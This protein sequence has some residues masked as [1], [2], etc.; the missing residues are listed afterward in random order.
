M[1]L[2]LCLCLCLFL[3]F[4]SRVPK[5]K[6]LLAS[7][8]SRFLKTFIKNVF[9]PFR[10]VPLSLV[11]FSFFLLFSC[12]SF[13]IFVFYHF[14][15]LENCV[16]SFLFSF[17]NTRYIKHLYQGSTVDV[18][19]VVGSPWRCGDLTTEAGKLGL[20]WATD[21]GESMIQLPRVGW[22]LLACENGASPDCTIVVVLD[23]RSRSH[24]YDHTA[25]L[26]CNEVDETDSHE[27]ITCD[28]L[29]RHLCQTQ[30]LQNVIYPQAPC[31]PQRR[32]MTAGTSTRKT[33]Q[34]WKLDG[35]LHSLHTL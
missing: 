2:S 12:F 16:S 30:V 23:T 5:I 14:C 35:F 24:V 33:V 19:S 15:V 13:L 31:R 17:L 22:R 7:V 21:L 34:L 10:V 25:A 9:E 4:C 6:N 29:P 28:G 20:G 11:L 1:F 8:A 27:L 18:S 26:C 32:C 3:F